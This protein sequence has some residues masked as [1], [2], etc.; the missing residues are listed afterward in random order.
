MPRW[1]HRTPPRFSLA[2]GAALL[3]FAGDGYSEDADRPAAARTATAEDVYAL[4]ERVRT[5]I[6]FIEARVGRDGRAGTGFFAAPGRVLTN[7]HV[8]RGADRL[9]VWANGVPYQARVL[10]QEL[11][12]DLAL[13]AL[14]EAAL[15]IK[16]LALAPEPSSVPGERI[17]IVSSHP[18]PKAPA[19]RQSLTPG[20]YRGPSWFEQPARRF[21][22]ALEI[23]A[24][25]KPGDSG[26]P[27]FRL[28]DGAVIGVLRARDNPEPAG[29]SSRAWAIP[30]DVAVPLLGS[31]TGADRR[32]TAGPD[33]R[34][35]LSRP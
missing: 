1:R 32:T 30:I 17:L 13:L 9:T 2:L 29:V 34:F 27:V 5:K 28:R 18:A 20:L 33:E 24:H 4:V 6:V 14:S 16:P 26:S 12:L 19:V 8:V 31:S 25:V 7:E 21:T 35:Y 3:F 22:R 10:A 11:D 23:S 15:L